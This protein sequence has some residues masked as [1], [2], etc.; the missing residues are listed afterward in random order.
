M[1]AGEPAAEVP[2]GNSEAKQT[3]QVKPLS[4]AQTDR[5]TKSETAP[6]LEVTDLLTQIDRQAGGFARPSHPEDV[7]DWS[8]RHG[9]LLRMA[10]PGRSA[11]PLLN[12]IPDISSEENMEKLIQDLESFGRSVTPEEEQDSRD[13]SLIIDFSIDRTRKGKT[14]GQPLTLRKQ[15]LYETLQAA[16]YRLNLPGKLEQAIGKWFTKYRE[17]QGNQY[18]QD[19]ARLAKSNTEYAQGIHAM[20][21]ER[22]PSGY[23]RV[24]RGSGSAGEWNKDPL[25]RE[26]INVTS[27]RVAASNFQAANNAWELEQQKLRN[28]KPVI[29]NIE[30][31]IEDV[32]ALGSIH[33][34]ELII[35][36]EALRRA[37]SG[38]QTAPENTPS[39][40]SKSIS[41]EK[42]QPL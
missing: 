26:F 2:S 29:D 22:Y 25:A 20:L 27:D 37:M 34:S 21:R 35:P 13:L 4:I 6:K 19:F 14:E 5:Q 33:E 23:I 31:K 3:P 28:L 36:S 30:I 40:T 8:V 32:L 17:Q 24:Y 15:E 7:Y 41:V 10:S 11:Q 39:E 42:P 9:T 18:L 16:D 38:S 1:P 12:L